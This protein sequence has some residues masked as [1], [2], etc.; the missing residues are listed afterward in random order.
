MKAP[1]LKSVLVA[2]AL[3][4]SAVVAHPVAAPPA[5]A[6]SVALSAEA[7]DAE[8]VVDAFHDALA[9]GDAAAAAAMLDDSAVIYEEGEAE[10]SRAA[11]VASHLP[12]DIAFL[13]GVKET[14]VDRVGGASSGTAWIATR[15]RIEGRFR[16]KPVNR[17]TTET[18][19][20]RRDAR[21]WRIVHIHW[22]S[23]SSPS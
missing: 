2:T 17:E 19:V 21:G 9:R 12:A 14:V 10:Q 4:S 6:P 13:K 3:W 23:K 11:Y 8:R 22:S 18:M 15:G 20:L 1:I 16:D 5:A 7:R